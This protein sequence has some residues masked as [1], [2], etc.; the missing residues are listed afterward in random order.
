MNAQNIKGVMTDL[1][2]RKNAKLKHVHKSTVLYMTRMFI[3]G[4][5]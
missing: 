2:F 4:A 3:W 5:H 1:N